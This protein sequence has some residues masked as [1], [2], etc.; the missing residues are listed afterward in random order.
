LKY[1]KE[2][3][4]FET[5]KLCYVAEELKADVHIYGWR[6]TKSQWRDRGLTGVFVHT[7]GS[8]RTHLLSLRP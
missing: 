1:I 6:I 3:T 4:Y 7:L 8:I 2:E 5:K